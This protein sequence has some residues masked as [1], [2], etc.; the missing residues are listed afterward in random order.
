MKPYERTSF[1]KIAEKNGRHKASANYVI[2]I[3]H[4]ATCVYND[5]AQTPNGELNQTR[6]RDRPMPRKRAHPAR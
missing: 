5:F 6:C 3:A 2:E 4:R 1:S